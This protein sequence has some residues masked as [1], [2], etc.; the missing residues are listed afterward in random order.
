ML[1]LV[2]PVFCRQVNL[3]PP[4]ESK[5]HSGLLAKT[6]AKPRSPVSLKMSH[7]IAV[8][9]NN[10]FVSATREQTRRQLILFWLHRLNKQVFPRAVFIWQLVKYE[11]KKMCWLPIVLRYKLGSQTWGLLKNFFSSVTIDIQHYICFRYIT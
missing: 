7:F 9:P 11:N 6:E 2:S 8:Q 3:D 5:H 4:I 1:V 10:S